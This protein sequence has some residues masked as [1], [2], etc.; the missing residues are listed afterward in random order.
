MDIHLYQEWQNQDEEDERRYD[1]SINIKGK[2]I[3]HVLSSRLSFGA[4]RDEACPPVYLIDDNGYESKNPL[5]II[6]IH[7]M[8]VSRTSSYD[9]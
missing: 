9:K 8:I 3:K 5:K 1:L 6:N 7:N 2:Y 4:G